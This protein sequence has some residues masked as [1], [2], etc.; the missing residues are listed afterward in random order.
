ATDSHI[1]LLG[2]GSGSD[3]IRDNK[4]LQ[5][6]GVDEG[7]N[8]YQLLAT[9]S[10]AKEF[11]GRISEWNLMGISLGGH[12]VLYAGIYVSQNPWNAEWPKVRSI[13]GYC[14]VVDLKPTLIEVDKTWVAGK[15]FR[16]LLSF[17]LRTFGKDIEATD[18]LP[19][20]LAKK[21]I[22][23][24]EMT[25]LL[26]RLLLLRYRD[27]AR[28]KNLFPYPFDKTRIHTM[29]DFWDLNDYRNQLQLNSIPTTIIS[30]EN[31]FIVN[32]MANQISL[33]K[34]LSQSPPNPRLSVI[35]L[36][37]GGHC[38]QAGS[39]SWELIAQTLN[40][41][42]G[43]S[44]SRPSAKSPRPLLKIL[45]PNAFP[46]NFAGY[47]FEV[48]KTLQISL[49]LIQTKKKTLAENF[50]CDDFA[51]GVRPKSCFSEVK[52]QVH[53]SL[54]RA[55]AQEFFEKDAPLNRTAMAMLMRALNVRFAAFYD[56]GEQIGLTKSDRTTR[57]I[58]LYPVTDSDGTL[59]P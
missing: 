21:G 39:Y 7:S 57:Q 6:G 11:S 17:I 42:L 59:T 23:Q 43:S 45:L 2:S 9:L 5:L 56:S 28:P 13:V 27:G 29:Q 12:A 25:P 47:R 49:V 58:F 50:N 1:F 3:S 34:H 37:K 4:R 36:Q 30:A 33:R 46:M 53:Q 41:L 10:E 20:T 18:V 32:P 40:H 55:V 52:V 8:V 16:G 19:P 35:D 26:E 44:N 31:D 15:M 22:R 51:I 38:G 14:P 54:G 48:S 24:G